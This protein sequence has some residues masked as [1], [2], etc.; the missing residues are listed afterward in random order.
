MHL[1]AVRRVSVHCVTERPAAWGEQA[2]GGAAG[3]GRVQRRATALQRAGPP[4]HGA[5]LHVVA[6]RAANELL[7]AL[8]LARYLLAIG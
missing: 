7:H 6:P 8:L 4:V 5:R 1:Y 3:A 2:G